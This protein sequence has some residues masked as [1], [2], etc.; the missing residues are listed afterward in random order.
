M[1]EAVTIPR[2]EYE[3]LLKCRHI[4]DAEFEEHFRPAFIFAVKESEEA[5]RNGRY[6]KVK[7]PSER[8]KL[9]NSL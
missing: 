3:F 1:T 5:Y 2:E 4:V 7:N 6:V 8:K 9:F